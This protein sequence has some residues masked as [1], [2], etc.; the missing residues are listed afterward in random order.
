M[1]IIADILN[2]I[3]IKL[4]KEAGLYRSKTKEVEKAGGL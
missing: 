4:M 2:Y 1:T 3:K